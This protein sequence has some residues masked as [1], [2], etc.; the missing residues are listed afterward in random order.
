MDISRENLVIQ[1]VDP[2]IA[3][4][5]RTTPKRAVIVLATGAITFFL[6]M[7]WIFIRNA[8]RNAASKPEEA[9]RMAQL[10]KA[11]RFFKK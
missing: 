4:I 10:K 5:K 9:T 8:M 1:V 6:T 11:W 2:A 3:P 7:L